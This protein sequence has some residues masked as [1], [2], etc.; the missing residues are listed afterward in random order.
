MGNSFFG[1]FKAERLEKKTHEQNRTGF[2]YPAKRLKFYGV[3]GF[4]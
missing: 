4:P 1:V 2:I 3:N